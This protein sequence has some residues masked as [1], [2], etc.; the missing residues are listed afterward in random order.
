M[1]TIPLCDLNG[2]QIGTV[3]SSHH[4]D[5]GS[6]SYYLYLDND[7]NTSRIDYTEAY[8]AILTKPRERVVS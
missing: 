5:D 8:T 1:N 3:I 7:G 6:R 4:F 2:Y